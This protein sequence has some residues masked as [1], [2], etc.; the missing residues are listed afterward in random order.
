MPENIKIWAAQNGRSPEAEARL[1]LEDAVSP[2]RTE[3][4]DRKDGDAQVNELQAAP[5]PRSR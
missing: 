4:V 2:T 5:G 1:I 3:L